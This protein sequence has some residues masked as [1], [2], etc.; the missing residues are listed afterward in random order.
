MHI[1]HKPGNTLQPQG[2]V[3][4]KPEEFLPGATDDRDVRSDL[5]LPY[6]HHRLFDI[7]QPRR[8]DIEGC[9][10][11]QIWLASA[12]AFDLR[13]DLDLGKDFIYV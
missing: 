11:I 1:D 9:D 3:F 8:F 13:K 4:Q 6:I 5:P 7:L 10:D 2:D 12:L